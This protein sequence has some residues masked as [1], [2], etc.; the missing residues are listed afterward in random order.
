MLHV[1]HPEVSLV[2]EAPGSVLV[3][4]QQVGVVGQGP[5]LA[6]EGLVH[7]SPL[8]LHLLQVGLSPAVGQTKGQ[9]P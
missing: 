1:S 6:L 3:Q 8:G 5:Q 4:Q 9:C 2:G 7:C